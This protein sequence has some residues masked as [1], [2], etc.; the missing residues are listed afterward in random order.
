ML[1][2]AIRSARAHADL[3]GVTLSVDVAP[4]LTAVLDASAVRRA[5][6][7]LLAN[8]VEYAAGGPGIRRCGCPPRT[9]T[10]CTR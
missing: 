6:D 5:V 7:N 10:T 1:H 2:A 3:A 9:A 4:E 8:A